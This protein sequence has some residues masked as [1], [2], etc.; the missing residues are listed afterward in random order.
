[1]ELPS[2]LV[3]F[4]EPKQVPLFKKNVVC[5]GNTDKS[6]RTK[7]SSDQL[8]TVNIGLTLTELIPQPV[9]NS[10]DRATNIR[11]KMH[12]LRLENN[13]SIYKQKTYP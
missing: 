4:K 10:F 11:W 2:H 8:Q 7:L 1:V 13:N 12:I 3:N 5:L 9:L 6:Y